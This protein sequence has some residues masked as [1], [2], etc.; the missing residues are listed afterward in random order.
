MRAKSRVLV[1]EEGYAIMALVEWTDELETGIPSVDTQ[2]QT[3][4]E[5]INKFDLG[6]RKGQGSHIMNEILSELIQYTGEHFVHEEKL[7]LDADFKKLHQHQSQ[8]RQLLEKIEKLQDDFNNKDK[9]ITKDVREFL[10][11]WLVN[12]IMK[13]DKAFAESLTEKV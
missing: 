5:I 2:H 10:K 11:Y 3:L 9:R 13:E 4:V 8:H 12:H 6:A 1:F 7:M